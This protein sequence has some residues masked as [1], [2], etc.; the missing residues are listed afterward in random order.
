MAEHL[1]NAESVAAGLRALPGIRKAF[2]STQ[3][4][5]RFYRNEGVTLEQ[6]AAPLI[7]AGREA[8][9]E[10]E[11]RYALVA[12]DWSHLDY[13]SHGSKADRTRLKGKN[14]WGYELATA[15]LLSEQTGAPLSILGQT[16]LAA[17]GLHSTRGEEVLP[18]VSQLDG[19]SDAIR[20]V[21][22]CELGRPAVHIADRECDSVGHYRQWQ[23]EQRFF[24][25]RGKTDTKLRF[26]E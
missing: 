15:L 19:L 14:L 1:N 12:H 17:E 7:A 11:G 9:A 16:L 20:F 4:A 22:S 8:L 26:K 13:S 25:V 23:Q 5:W 24:V 6:L 18:E 21:D 10:T 2:A 3:A